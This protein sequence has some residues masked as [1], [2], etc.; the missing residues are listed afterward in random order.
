[1]KKKYK[2]NENGQALVFFL[3][4]ALVLVLSTILYQERIERI[5]NGTMPVQCD[6]GE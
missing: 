1:M 4:T 5:S 6:C 3:L 2:L